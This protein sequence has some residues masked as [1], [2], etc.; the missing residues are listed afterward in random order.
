ME[1]F[2]RLITPRTKAILICNPNNPTGYVYSEEEYAQLRDIVLA[3]P[4]PDGGLVY[5]EFC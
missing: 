5:R 2:E 4:V 3:R 1:D